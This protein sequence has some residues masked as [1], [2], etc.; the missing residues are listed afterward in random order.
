MMPH[1]LF[2]KSST[3][4]VVAMRIQETGTY[5]NQ[6]LRPYTTDLDQRTMSKVVDMAGQAK[7]TGQQITAIG[8]AALNDGKPIVTPS[9]AP[10]AMI[11]IANGWTE[12]R[13][14][15]LLIVDQA[16][17]VG[18][19]HRFYITGYSTH[20]DA[21]YS[22]ALD[23]DMQFF[24]NSVV[25]TRIVEAVTP[26][27][28]VVTQEAI[29]N[30]RHVIANNNWEGSMAANQLYMM[31]PEDI[32]TT[33]GLSS[34]TRDTHDVWQDTRIM[35][36]RTATTSDLSNGLPHHY[37]SKIL[38]TYIAA[39][40]VQPSYGNGDSNVISDAQKL[41]INDNDNPFIVAISRIREFGYISNSFT[42]NEMC[43]IDPNAYSKI[44]YAPLEQSDYSII[45]SAG[46]TSDW[47]GQDGL[48]MAAIKICQA[49]PGL[50][51][52][53]MLQN[54]NF[55]STNST[56]DSMFQTRVSYA[57][58]MNKEN[59]PMRCNA[60]VT[61][62]EQEVLRDV[63]VNNNI[64]YY[65]D[66]RADVFGETWVKLS[67]NGSALIEYVVP[68]FCDNLLAPIVTSNNQNALQ[69]SS[70]FGVLLNDIGETSFARTE[71]DLTGMHI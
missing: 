65:L 17:H 23:R 36:Q 34:M 59:M 68:S 52:G 15:F 5:N 35:A 42:I 26:M 46:Q 9:A 4:H 19:V 48:T 2:D 41:C 18:G 64:A 43:R 38:N 56:M 70:D 13:F 27:H 44:Q 16:F 25:R 31:R 47:H 12:R 49:I 37:A 6:Y 1:E 29:V 69:I 30:N 58:S 67:F 7:E 11:S 50:M 57:D 45:H 10:E 62:F 3:L 28:G 53:L 66:V 55:T 54:I 20:A 33:I 60:F 61:R 51:G 71:L 21:G 22:G 32:Y 24:I 8:M 14:R 39:S 40:N 63:T